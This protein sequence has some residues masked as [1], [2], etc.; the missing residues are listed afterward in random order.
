MKTANIKSK[1][2]AFLFVKNIVS[3][4]IKATAVNNLGLEVNEDFDSSCC[5]LFSSIGISTTPGQ[6]VPSSSD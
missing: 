2:A 1:N 4:S 5:L 6:K 3:T